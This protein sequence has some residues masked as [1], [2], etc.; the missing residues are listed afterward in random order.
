MIALR[1]LP[2]NTFSTLISAE[3]AIGAMVG[4]ILLGELLSP[5]QWLAIGLVVC[6]SVGAAMG[7]KTPVVQE[8]A[9]L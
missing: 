1:R 4:F 9:P 2:S 3:P 8:P 6:A 5:M 7:S